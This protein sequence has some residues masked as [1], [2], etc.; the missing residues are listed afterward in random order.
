MREGMQV[1]FAVLMIFLARMLV[2]VEPCSLLDTIANHW[3]VA[4]DLPLLNA[5]DISMH[6]SVRFAAFRRHIT[7]RAGVHAG[8]TWSAEHLS[9]LHHCP[10]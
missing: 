10:S 1:R 6:A 5:R 4:G 3:M 9:R 2:P 8:Q 7:E